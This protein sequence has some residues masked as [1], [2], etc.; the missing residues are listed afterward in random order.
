VCNFL[1]LKC[2]IIPQW[3]TEPTPKT[4]SIIISASTIRGDDAMFRF[5][6]WKHFCLTLNHCICFTR[7]LCIFW[8][9]QV[10]N[11][12]R[13]KSKRLSLTYRNCTK[14]DTSSVLRVTVQYQHNEQQCTLNNANI[15]Q[16]NLRVFGYSGVHESWSVKQL[17]GFLT[18]FWGGCSESRACFHLCCR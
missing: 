9:W 14:K 15:L 8:E 3:P 11:M 17:K 13:E 16:Q 1:K 18:I 10:H 6:S 2:N 5:Q 12:E 4:H 7:Q